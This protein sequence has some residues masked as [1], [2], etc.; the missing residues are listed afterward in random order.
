MIR[1]LPAQWDLETD[2]LAIGSGIG[3]L[4]A[5]ITAYDHGARA[6]VLERA[7]R[8]GGVTALSVG[9]VWVAGNHL[10]PPL[11]IKDST[12]SGYRYLKR[13]SMDYGEDL[14]IL[15]TVVHAA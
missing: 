15:N 4:S 2:V 8:V 11:G 1:N 5:A 7:E 14:T 3:G 13:L 10:G 6:M 12:E 9:Q